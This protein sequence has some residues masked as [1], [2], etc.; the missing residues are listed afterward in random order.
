MALQLEEAGEGG[1]GGGRLGLSVAKAQD[2]CGY[3]M[4]PLARHLAA[5]STLRRQP[6]SLRVLGV[7]AWGGARVVC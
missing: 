3:L 6:D 7:G 1:V 2:V 4:L 5:A